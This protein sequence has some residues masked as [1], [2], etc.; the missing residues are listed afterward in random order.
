M[1]YQIKEVTRT[2]VINSFIFGFVFSLIEIT[3]S[4][5]FLISPA[6]DIPEA[7]VDVKK[8]YDTSKLEFPREINISN[9]IRD[10][11]GYRPY[12]KNYIKNGTILTIGG[13]STDQ[14][15][16]DDNRTWQS[17]LENDLNLA[18]INGGVDGQT[19]YGHIFS[20]ENWH[21]KSLITKK[22]DAIIFYIG[23]NDVRFAKGLESVDGNI[24]D[25]PTMLR[26]LRSFLS[27]RSFFYGKIRDVKT[28]LNYIFGRELNIPNG[29]DKIGHNV[30]N[31]NFLAIP[32]K[33]NAL[34]SKNNEIYPYQLLFEKLI[35]NT[36]NKFPNAAINIVQQQDPKCLI[37]K[38]NNDQIY[39][40]V[41]K[42][43]VPNI[44]LYCVDLASIYM[45][46]EK[47]IR[48]LDNQK[49]N[50]IKMYLDSPIPDSGFY[51]GLHTNSEGAS[52]IANYLKT[53]LKI[54]IP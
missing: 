47:V 5:Y 30:Q 32:Q 34:M 8:K 41:S 11:N 53:R 9:Y 21:S 40:R 27:N 7:Q 38:L 51:D 20:I 22:I 16:V 49:I 3:L 12:N 28:K 4:K 6:F 24:Y 48:E 17:N 37:N 1:K 29:T 15:F 19:T 42:K 45:G 23:I 50:L 25:S 26:R 31:P 36:Q 10:K 13:S 44:D 54:K 2:L 39:F 35:L 43:E 46:Q 14:R 18:V 52:Y 33:S